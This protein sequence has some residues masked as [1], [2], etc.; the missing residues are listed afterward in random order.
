MNTFN[1]IANE[2]PGTGGPPRNVLKGNYSKGGGSLDMSGVM[3]A[4]PLKHEKYFTPQRLYI[5]APLDEYGLPLREFTVQSKLLNA[6]PP[7]TMCHLESFNMNNFVG[8][9]QRNLYGS[10]KATIGAQTMSVGATPTLTIVENPNSLNFG[11]ATAGALITFQTAEGFRYIGYISTTSATAPVITIINPASPTAFQ[12]GIN[13]IPLHQFPVF[14]IVGTIAAQ[15]V[16]C[17]FTWLESVGSGQN[18][19]GQIQVELMN[20]TNPEVFDTATGQYSRIIGSVPTHNG[21]D[22]EIDHFI[23]ASIN[24]AG[25]PVNDPNLINNRQLTF[26]ITYANN[27]GNAL[28]PPQANQG[29]VYPY[30]LAESSYFPLSG[31]AKIPWGG[32]TTSTGSYT[33]GTTPTTAKVF[34][35]APVIR[36]CLVFLPMYGIT[37]QYE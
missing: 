9:T 13:C 14:N 25:Y 7:N 19:I 31:G 22:V 28:V 27:S 30:N 21:S 24:N 37:K 15:T 33:S 34:P 1:K 3:N 11:A 29:Q 2:L 8:F 4:I 20:Y 10:F 12:V 26:R 16:I 5:T 32:V 17:N 23:S 6:L 18:D 36:F 35:L